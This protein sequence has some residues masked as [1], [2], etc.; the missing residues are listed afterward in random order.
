MKRLFPLP[1]LFAAVFL[2]APCLAQNSPPYEVALPGY[3][4]SFPRDN[5]N[6]P[7]YQTEWW[8]YTGNLWT[9][10]GRRF[11]FELTF[12]RQG[13]SRALHPASVWNVH[14]VYMAH[15]ALSDIRGQKFY[16]S[17]RL[18]RVGPGLAGIDESMDKIWNG[19]WQA[20]WNGDHQELQAVT[21]M[22][23]FEFDLNSSKPPV[24]NGI[25]GMSQKATG[26]GHA[27]HYISLTRL[28]AEGT[29]RL[30]GHSYRVKGSAWMDHEFFTEQL[31]G[32]PSGWDWTCMQF[33]DDTELMLYRLRHQDG[34]EDPYSSGTYVNAAGHSQHLTV[35]DF[36]MQPETTWTSPQTHARYPVNWRV[37]VPSLGI[38]LAVTTPLKRQELVSKNRFT[39]TYW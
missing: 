39:P 31:S 14:D 12:F 9:A 17:Q 35:K 29:V 8:Y 16:D 15:A 33:D 3:H 19:N 25:N 23:A 2:V 36:Q 13:V 32:S 21:D 26:R 37:E 6:H 38:N 27:S 20:V 7:A 28:A 5:F 22:F 10:A 30:S 11:G 34:S 4:Y 1:A 18:N 24:I